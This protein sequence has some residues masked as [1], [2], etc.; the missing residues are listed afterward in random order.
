MRAPIFFFHTSLSFS[1]ASRPYSLRAR[2][3]PT[4]GEI[5]IKGKPFGFDVNT[6]LAVAPIVSSYNLTTISRTRITKRLIMAHCRPRGAKVGARA[7]VSSEKSSKLHPK[8]CG[9]PF[10]SRDCCELFSRAN[11]DADSWKRSLE[12]NEATRGSTIYAEPD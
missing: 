10:P 8:Q 12:R 6:R 9:V 7:R 3:Q 11:E 5:L 1:C 4:E 2:A